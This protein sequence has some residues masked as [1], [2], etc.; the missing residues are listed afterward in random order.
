VILKAVYFAYPFFLL[1][2][3]QFISSQRNKCLLLSMCVLFLTE[4]KHWPFDSVLR[5]KLPK[6]TKNNFLP[7]KKQLA[8]NEKLLY[9]SLSVRKQTC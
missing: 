3:L 5:Q 9:P 8:F 1:A 6:E 2:N 7:K 4:D